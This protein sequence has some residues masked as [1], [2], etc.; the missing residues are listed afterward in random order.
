MP[1]LNIALL[2]AYMVSILAL[3][4]TPGPVVMLVTGTAASSG[5]GKAFLTTFGTNLASLVLI[6]LAVMMLGGVVTL[7]TGYLS[8]L[9]LAGSL[10]IGWGAVQTLISLRLTSTAGAE[11]ESVISGG[12]ARG[13]VTGVANPKD[14]LFFV[15]FFPQFIGISRDFTTS[16][17]TLSLVWIL[18]DFA[19]MAGYILAV[20]R[21][22]PVALGRRFA[23]GSALMLLAIAGAGI[24]W[25]LSGV[26]AFIFE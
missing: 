21:F 10:Y 14:I 24:L 22:L 18:F 20:K 2:S 5:Y 8:L 26:R 23:A 4:L 1:A 16:I 12:F 19:V 6:L 25:N 15:S 11:G 9:G 13:F 3:L 7:N 17:I